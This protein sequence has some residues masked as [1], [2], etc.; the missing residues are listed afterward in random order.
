[1]TYCTASCHFAATISMKTT[2][3]FIEKHVLMLFSLNRPNPQN[4][5][6]FDVG[7]HP[8]ISLPQHGCV[9]RDHALIILSSCVYIVSCTLR[10]PL[11]LYMTNTRRKWHL[12]NFYFTLSLYET[13]DCPPEIAA[14]TPL[15]PYVDQ[16]Q[17]STWYLHTRWSPDV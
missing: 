7:F 11:S 17:F 14:L 3:S 12:G 8:M 16:S 10:R 9:V 2:I 13:G 4:W 6:L 1:M 15:C 5:G